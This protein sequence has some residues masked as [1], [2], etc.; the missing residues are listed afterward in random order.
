MKTISFG[1]RLRAHWRRSFITALSTW[2][3]EYVTV[4]HLPISILWNAKG[5]TQALILTT[6]FQTAEAFFLNLR[7]EESKGGVVLMITNT[8]L[9]VRVI[10]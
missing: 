2:A 4:T 6:V 1:R 8:L 10:A 7:E 5:T 3:Y 9:Q